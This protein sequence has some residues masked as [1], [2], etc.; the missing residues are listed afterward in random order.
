MRFPLR[1]DLSLDELALDATAQVSDLTL[2]GALAGWPS[3]WSAA[4]SAL[5]ADTAGLRF[6]GHGPTA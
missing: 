2:P 5:Q 4:P 6:E 1:A 3:G